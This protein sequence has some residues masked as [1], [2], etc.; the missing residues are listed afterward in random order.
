MIRKAGVLLGFSLI[1][2]PNELEMNW[3]SCSTFTSIDKKTTPLNL[4]ISLLISI[5]ILQRITD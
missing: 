4:L 5:L 1:F 2:Q 3:Y